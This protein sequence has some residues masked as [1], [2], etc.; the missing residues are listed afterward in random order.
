VLDPSP[1]DGDSEDNFI[2]LWDCLV[3]GPLLASVPGSTSDRNRSIGSDTE[4]GTRPDLL[5]WLSGYLVFRGEEKGRGQ[6]LRA[7]LEELATKLSVW[8]Y[9]DHIPYLLGYAASGDRLRFAALYRKADGSTGVQPLLREFVLSNI[10]DRLCVFQATRVI[11]GILPQLALALHNAPISPDVDFPAPRRKTYNHHQVSVTFC[12]TTVK[13][14]YTGEHGMA[15]FKRMK[16]LYKAVTAT[17]AP[18]TITLTTS[19]HDGTLLLSPLGLPNPLPRDVDQLGAILG[20]VLEALAWLHKNG[21]AHRDLRWPN[22]AKYKDAPG[23]FLLDFDDGAILTDGCSSNDT[24]SHLV[25]DN[26]APEMSLVGGTHGTPVDIWSV[27]RLIQTC[28][29]GVAAFPSAVEQFMYAAPADRP[30]AAAAAV[31]LS[32]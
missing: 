14:Q 5:F 7:P 27:G 12:K 3:R 13:K 17:R 16:I 2:A 24:A 8:P 23:W 4:S 1:S 18:F 19:F 22:I 10:D 9:E 26:H 31:L 30:D 6:Q 29:L 21:I 15:V 20:N 11:A 28:H 25:G 32:T